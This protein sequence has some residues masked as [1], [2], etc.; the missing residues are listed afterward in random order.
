MF[1][2]TQDGSE[3][4]C[5]WRDLRHNRDKLSLEQVLAKFESIKLKSRYLDY[6]T[7]SSWPGVFEIVQDGYFCQS[8]LTLVIATTLHHLG[9]INTNELQLHAIS[10]HITGADGLVLEHNGYYYNFI[11]G[12]AVT[13][14]YA[15]EHSTRYDSYIIAVDNLFA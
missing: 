7:P 9:F 14:E 6:Y 10:N 5:A 15:K 1:T 4:L 12:T 8:G 3:R 2:N 11:Q 13:V